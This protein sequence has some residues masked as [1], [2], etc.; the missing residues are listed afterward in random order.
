MMLNEKLNLHGKLGCLLAIVGS[1]I[2]IIH[3]PE[4]S[5]V[6]DIYEI[7]RNMLSLGIVF[8]VPIQSL[9]TVGL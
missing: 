7:G 5:E 6:N 1:T 4:E 9:S 8:L 3:A 2:I